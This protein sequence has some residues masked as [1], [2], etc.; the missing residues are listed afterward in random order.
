MLH[1][2]LS[3]VFVL[4]AILAA[5]GAGPVSAQTQADSS[6]L[7]DTGSLE[8][9][10]SY[11]WLKT[12]NPFTSWLPNYHKN[13]LPYIFVTTTITWTDPLTAPAGNG[14]LRGNWEGLLSGVATAITDGPEHHWFGGAAG[15]RYNFVP[16]DPSRW[17]PFIDFRGG[18]GG[19][20]AS[21]VKYG[22]ERDLTFTFLIGVGVRY[23]LTKDTS[24]IVQSL[25]QHISNGWQTHPSEGVDLTGLAI[26]CRSRF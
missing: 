8:A 15:L 17:T 6:S 23:S 19:L 22:Q 16:K 14:I 7:A 9:S 24:V 12:P 5:G 25:T 18:V 3:G 1:S 21:N 2:S 4:A 13:P 20:D 10:S 11:L 26:G